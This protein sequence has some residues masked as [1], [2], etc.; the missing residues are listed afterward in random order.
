MND[1][2]IT[3]YRLKSNGMTATINAWPDDRIEWFVWRQ[4]NG[5]FLGR[6]YEASVEDAKAAVI[7][8]M[9]DLSEAA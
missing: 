5:Q 3:Q 1:W 4:S 6:R 8:F 9:A 2:L 7:A